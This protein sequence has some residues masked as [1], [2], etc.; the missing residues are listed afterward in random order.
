MIKFAPKQITW[1]AVRDVVIH[2]ICLGESHIAHFI[3]R[4]LS[5]Q[6]KV[7]VAGLHKQAAGGCV[8]GGSLY[9]RQDEMCC[10]ALTQQKLELALAS[11]PYSWLPPPPRPSAGISSPR[12]GYCCGCVSVLAAVRRRLGSSVTCSAG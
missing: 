5:P 4:S 9:L 12:P 11:G 10:P 8:Q 7:F 3:N 6:P 2:A 1:L